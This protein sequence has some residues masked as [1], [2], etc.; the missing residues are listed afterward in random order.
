MCALVAPAV[1]A[2]V[3]DFVF[4]VVSAAAQLKP[5]LMMAAVRRKRNR[6]LMSDSES[7]ASEEEKDN[8]SSNTSARLNTAVRA[9]V[10]DE[11]DGFQASDDESVSDSLTAGR[12]PKRSTA[13]CIQEISFKRLKM[14]QQVTTH[15]THTY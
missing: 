15:Y 11:S 3:C 1:D 14:R 13:D 9:G 6:I 10:M 4:P 2:L 5:L 12:R 7:A 8:N